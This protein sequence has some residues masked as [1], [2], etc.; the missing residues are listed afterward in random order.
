MKSRKEIIKSINDLLS[1]NSQFPERDC[2][3][4]IWIREGDIYTAG[5]HRLTADE[6][7]K[8]KNKLPVISFHKTEI[9][10]P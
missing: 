2:V 1:N 9:E 6:F 8:L 5:P 3:P 4:L 10:T 7:E